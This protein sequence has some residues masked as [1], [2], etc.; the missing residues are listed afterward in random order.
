MTE[1]TGDNK[2]EVFIEVN[3]FLFSLT[4]EENIFLPSYKGSTLR[5]GFG[6]AFKRI[7][8]ALKN[9]EC[10][11]C[12]LKE[13]CVYSYIFETP[14]PASAKIMKKYKSAPHPFVIE[15]P[16]EKQK[17]YTPN[18]EII[19]GLKL[20][21]K[22][23]EY[24]PYFI[25]AFDELGKI[26]I[27]KG[28]AKYRIKTIRNFKIN[29]IKE[30][31]IKNLENSKIIY[32][33]ED[34][35]L[36][37]S[38]PSTILLNLNINDSKTYNSETISLNFITPTRIVYENHL[39]LNL[40]FH[41]LIRQLLRRL[42]LIYYFHCGGD[43]TEW[44]FNEIIKRAQEVEIKDRNLRWYDWQRYSTRQDTRMK[45]GG[46]IGDITFEGNIKPF[47]SLIKAGEI[48]HVGK[49]TGFGLGKYKIVKDSSE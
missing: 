24:L 38:N 5:G 30:P 42:S 25:Y 45:M 7:V 8:C 39:I 47:M 9:K 41:V 34:K 44:E 22:A 14:P 31:E 28:K 43:P 15:P 1:S 35:I 2:Q 26:G 10:A 27:G 13:R 32:N 19:F 23:N 12:F 46:F 48:L 11:D 6:H 20:I 33:S 17:I 29:N 40:E 4:P 21:G 18:D 36:H 3:C 16:N 49:G 37:L